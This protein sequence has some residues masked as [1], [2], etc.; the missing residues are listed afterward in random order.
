MSTTSL[1]SETSML[2]ARSAQTKEWITVG[3]FGAPH[4]I[5]GYVRLHSFTSPMDN[6]LNYTHLKIKKGNTHQP[7]EI[8]VTQIR[9][10]DMVVKVE[11]VDDRNKACELTHCEI[12]IDKSQ[13]A[14][15]SEGEFYWHQLIG[16]TVLNR[17]NEKIGVV[18]DL[19]E[20]G[21][22][23]V[24]I[25][26]KADGKKTLIPYLKDHFIDKIDLDNKTIFVDWDITD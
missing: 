2:D 25:V 1:T 16:L 13:L 23:D 4:G 5:N 26:K 20:T 19:L 11:G 12:L 9:S 7:I 8:T 21:S 24:L 22:N 6:I 17:N 18:E 3:K 10:K 14:D 15:L